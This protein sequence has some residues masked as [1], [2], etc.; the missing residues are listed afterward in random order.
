MTMQK[1]EIQMLPGDARGVLEILNGQTI[2]ARDLIWLEPLAK[3][4]EEMTT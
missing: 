3:Q 4:L 1:S 2:V